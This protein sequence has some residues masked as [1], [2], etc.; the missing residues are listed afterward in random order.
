MLFFFDS[1]HAYILAEATRTLSLIDDN[2]HEIDDALWLGHSIIPRGFSVCEHT[3]NLPANLGSNRNGPSADVVH[4][5]DDLTGDVRF[6]DRPYVTG[7]PMARFYAGVPI[8]TSKGLNIGAYCIVDDKPRNGL[9][10]KGV[11]FLRD[12]AAT[13]MTHLEMVR[14]SADQR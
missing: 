5:I 1:S 9:D 14:H 12:M 11:S 7:G 8:T 10:E 6:C 3:V 2:I 13:V 4:I